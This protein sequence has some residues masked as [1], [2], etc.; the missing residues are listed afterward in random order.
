MISK[1]FVKEPLSFFVLMYLWENSNSP[2]EFNY[3]EIEEELDISKYKQKKAINFLVENDMLHIHK[4]FSEKRKSCLAEVN[5]DN[6]HVERVVSHMKK[7][8]ELI[9]GITKEDMTREL[10]DKPVPIYPF[11]ISGNKGKTIMDYGMQKYTKAFFGHIG[12]DK[13]TNRDLACVFALCG[14]NRHRDLFFYRLK[15]ANWAGN[16]INRYFSG[17]NK[18]DFLSV[19][20][21][22]IKEYE[23]KYMNGHGLNWNYIDK[24]KQH[25]E[26]LL[27]RAKENVTISLDTSLDSILWE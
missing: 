4:D 15:R 22:F 20:L 10:D 12:W 25:R 5:L 9:P 24:H 17:I 11:K 16:V 26:E 7:Q 1:K 8:G 2:V 23:N 18:E 27:T 6:P 3:K 19:S 21:E 14:G 13:V